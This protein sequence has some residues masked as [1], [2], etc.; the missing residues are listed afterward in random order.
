ML[1]HFFKFFCDRILKDLACGGYFRGIALHSNLEIVL[2]SDERKSRN[3]WGDHAALLDA[4]L[5]EIY[6]VNGL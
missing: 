2:K 3:I 6:T 5:L 4:G 1:L